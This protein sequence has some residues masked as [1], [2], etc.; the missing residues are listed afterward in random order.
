MTRFNVS[1]AA[2]AAA[3]FLFVA[4]CGGGGSPAADEAAIRE[5]NAKWLVAIAAKDV[6]A[7]GQIY[8]E[9]GQ[10]LPANAPKAV[11]RDAVEKGWGEM[12]TIPG[13]SLTF[14]TDTFVFAKSGDLAIDIGTYNFG[15]G[16]GAAAAIEVGKY[17]VTWTKRD[18]KWFVLTD[19]FSSDAPPASAPAA[20]VTPAA[21]PS[22]AKAPAVGT[23]MH[24]EGCIRKGVENKC[25][26]VE[27]NGVTYNV[28][29]GKGVLRIDQYAAGTG[30]VTDKVSYCMQGP[31]LDPITLDSKQPDKVCTQ[32]P[33][34]K[35][36]SP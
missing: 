22:P 9:D 34:A 32:T 28:T 23:T 6:K 7:V 16:E 2:V 4:A 24:F 10:L 26:V 1:V 36:K 29:S 31:V 25:L 8:A 14:E 30:V 3:C 5:A 20:S 19:M 18:G 13:M 15:S 11:G 12:F 17:V 21:E 27:S 35:P 33:A